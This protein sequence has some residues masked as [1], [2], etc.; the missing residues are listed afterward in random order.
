MSV[1]TLGPEKV[2]SV[3]QEPPKKT[4]LK[5]QNNIASPHRSKARELKTCALKENTLHTPPTTSRKAATKPPSVFRTTSMFSS[6][7]MLVADDEEIPQSSQF[8]TEFHNELF[9]LSIH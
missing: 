8:L 5:N 9:D 3:K 1:E 2:P 7:L 6:H 4:P